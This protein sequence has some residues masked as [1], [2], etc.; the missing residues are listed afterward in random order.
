M[1][2][3]IR[4]INGRFIPVY[5]QPVSREMAETV[6]PASGAVPYEVPRDGSG[7]EIEKETKYRGQSKL[8]VA[9]SKAWDK[10]ASG[11]FHVFNSLM[12]RLIGKPAQRNE[13]VN[14][15]VNLVEFIRDLKM[16]TRPNDMLT[17]SDKVAGV[18]G[19]NTIEAEIVEPAEEKDYGDLI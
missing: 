13:N 14:V 8:E 18:L 9:A 1:G 15:E 11:D 17:D 19:L 2:K 6:I 12:D 4:I 3:E 7:K 5:T 10:A 16:P